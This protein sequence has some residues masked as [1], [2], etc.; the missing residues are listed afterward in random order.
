[1]T[2]IIKLQGVVERLHRCAAEHVS[3]LPVTEKFQG[4]T[5]WSGNVELFRLHGHKK[6]QLCYAWSF[7]DDNGIEQFSTV[8]K[9]PPVVSAETAVSAD[10]VARSKNAK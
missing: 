4:E 9:L 1:L 5:V 8:L 3:T 10:I 7:I 6:A 2:D